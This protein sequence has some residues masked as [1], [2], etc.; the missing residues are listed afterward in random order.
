MPSLKRAQVSFW[1]LGAKP[2]VLFTPTN[3]RDWM[4]TEFKFKS[5]N[6]STK[7]WLHFLLLSISLSCIHRQTHRHTHLCIFYAWT[8]QIFGF[9]AF[10][11]FAFQHLQAQNKMLSML[12]VCCSSTLCGPVSFNIQPDSSQ[13]IPLLQ[14][15]ERPAFT[16]QSHLFIYSVVSMG[17]LKWQYNGTMNI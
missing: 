17:C 12:C 13:T 14:S 1:V 6:S 9:F 16:N 5:R 8:F 2:P 4:E 15:G 3:H 7:S 11:L 10:S